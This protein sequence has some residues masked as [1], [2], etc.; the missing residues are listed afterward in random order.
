MTAADGYP[1]TPGWRA[2]STGETARA[3]ALAMAPKVKG[4]RAA[5][6]ADLIG[7]G[8][9][10]PEEIARRTRHALLTT[11][12]PRCSELTR[13]GLIRDSKLRR[14]GEGGRPAIVWTTCTAEERA[15]HAARKAA[16]VEHG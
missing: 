7:H 15:L 8:P 4:I 2:N 6:L 11:V 1:H 14:P 3:A 10:T 5:V 9:S 12:R 16:E 13:L